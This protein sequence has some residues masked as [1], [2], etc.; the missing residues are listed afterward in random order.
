MFITYE[1]YKNMGG[2]LDEAAF[3]LYAYEAERK[4]YTATHGRVKTATEA[5]KRCITR[6]ISILAKSDIAADKV[7][8]FSND[9]VSQSIKDVSAS[10]YSAAVDNIIRE[11]LSGEV[12]KN[13][14]PLLYLGVDAND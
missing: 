4:I 7:T 8:S 13:G 9:G 1:E 14:V 6:L 10:D 3:N 5:I 11:Y 12:D 2:G